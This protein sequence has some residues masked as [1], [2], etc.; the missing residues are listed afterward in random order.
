MESRTGIEVG[1]KKSE[2]L[3]ATKKSKNKIFKDPWVF[4]LQRRR[5]QRLALRRIHE[6]RKEI[7]HQ[8]FQIRRQRRKKRDQAQNSIPVSSVTTTKECRANIWTLTLLKSSALK[9]T[10]CSSN[11]ALTIIWT[12]KWMPITINI[13]YKLIVVS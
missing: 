13:Y 11:R 3:S 4:A 5:P 12:D 9:R 2:L 8:L 7:R 10:E 1:G 6:R